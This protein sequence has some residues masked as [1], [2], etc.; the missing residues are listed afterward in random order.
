MI[1]PEEL[2]ELNMKGGGK[3]RRSSSMEAMG[4]EG[5]GSAEVVVQASK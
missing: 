1:P 2:R 5:V 4:A 3:R